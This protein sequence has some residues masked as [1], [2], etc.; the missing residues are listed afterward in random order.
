MQL[1]LLSRLQPT[2]KPPRAV[3]D[4]LET[5]AVTARDKV[6]PVTAVAHRQA[7]KEGRGVMALRVGFWE[8]DEG[9]DGGEGSK[10]IIMISF[11]LWVQSVTKS[12]SL[13]PEVPFAKSNDVVGR[14]S[15]STPMCLA[16]RSSLVD[17]PQ[18]GRTERT[19]T[20]TG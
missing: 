14:L 19:S 6:I 12:V 5:G 16:Y 15:V 10:A 20:P 8:T 13:H 2:G 4:A 9:G 11:S 18:V 3:Y 7:S 17:Q 1:S